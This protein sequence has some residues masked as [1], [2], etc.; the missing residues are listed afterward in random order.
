MK[1]NL[2]NSQISPQVVRG[3]LKTFFI[4]FWELTTL[5]VTLVA[6]F[7]EISLEIDTLCI[8]LWELKPYMVSLF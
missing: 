1:S 8:E 7:L 6:K 2:P 3:Q 5:L 4:G